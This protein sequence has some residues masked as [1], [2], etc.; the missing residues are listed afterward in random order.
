MV[1]K[2]KP[3][4]PAS[5]AHHLFAIPSILTHNRPPPSPPPP[6]KQLSPMSPVSAKCFLTTQVKGEK[7][8]AVPSR[9]MFQLASF[10]FQAKNPLF[11]TTCT[12]PNKWILQKKNNGHRGTIS[13]Q[14]QR[15]N[16]VSIQKRLLFFRENLLLK[17]GLQK[18]KRLLNL[19]Y[20]ILNF[21][22]E[23]GAHHYWN[24]Y[25]HAK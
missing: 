2:Q 12:C 17:F 8:M 24:V 6:L 7:V 22:P 18:F 20:L 19:I 5:P 11:Q 3:S 14:G 25:H 23:I 15:S 16:F 4:Q 9:V 21:A 1:I 10:F 13:V